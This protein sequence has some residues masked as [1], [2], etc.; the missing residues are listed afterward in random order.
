MLSFANAFA[1]PFDSITGAFYENENLKTH[2]NG[3]LKSPDQDELRKVQDELESQSVAGLF[4]TVL[5]ALGVG[6]AYAAHRI[7]RIGKPTAVVVT[8]ASLA[9]IV[10]GWD[11]QTSS[12]NLKMFF[13][14]LTQKIQTNS[15]VKIDDNTNL[16]DLSKK[17]FQ[18]RLMQEAI[19]GTLTKETLYKC[20]IAYA[21][22][23]KEITDKKT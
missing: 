17:Q 20:I 2:F 7:P 11:I 15:E 4:T 13:E 9:A 14:E 10:F 12:S 8:V 21:K 23:H 6:G 18:A 1:T 16:K 5:G 3:S 19:K 22:I